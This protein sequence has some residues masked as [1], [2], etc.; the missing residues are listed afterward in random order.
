MK[1][2]FELEINRTSG[3]RDDQAI[4][5]RIGD[6]LSGCRILEVYFG[7][8][9]FMEILTGRSGISAEGEFYPDN[10]IGCTPEHKEEIV[11]RPKGYKRNDK[12]VAKIVGPF[13][14]DG[15]KARTDDL[16]NHHHWVGT[17]RVRVSFSRFVRPDGSVWGR[18]K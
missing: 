6:D 4:S 8:A 14:V 5:V 2:N 3:G 9:E 16:Y 1:V 12:E 13:E 11:P 10:P 7:L 18:S 15:W 17:E